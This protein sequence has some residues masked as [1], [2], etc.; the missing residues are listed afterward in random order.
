MMII[1]SLSVVTR[2]S[3]RF[4]ILFTSSPVCLS[5]YLGNIHLHLYTYVYIY[6]FI[7]F[8]Y[9]YTVKYTSRNMSTIHR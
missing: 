4:I 6:I 8:M 5:I 9:I 7:Y 1:R 3:L 2:F